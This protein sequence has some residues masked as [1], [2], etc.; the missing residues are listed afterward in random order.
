MRT[1]ESAD[2]RFCR[3]LDRIAARWVAAFEL[4]GRSHPVVQ[5]YDRRYHRLIDER[6][7]RLYPRAG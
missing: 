5:H 4:H 3:L 6:V 2:R 1:R 7:A